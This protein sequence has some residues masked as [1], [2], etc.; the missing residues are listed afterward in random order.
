MTAPE[1]LV[2]ATAPVLARPVRGARAVV[3]HEHL[4]A[5]A[6]SVSGRFARASLLA[7]CGRRG[8]V[9]AFARADAVLVPG[10]SRQSVPEHLAQPVPGQH[11]ER[12]ELARPLPAHPG[13]TARPGIA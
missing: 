13:P 8:L 7:H 5:P 12:A 9:D 10:H 4:A 11:L 3:L 6:G 1:Y 2:P